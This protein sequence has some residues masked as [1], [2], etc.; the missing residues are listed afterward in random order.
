MNNLRGL[1]NGRQKSSMLG[2]KNQGYMIFSRMLIKIFLML[3]KSNGEETRK[4]VQM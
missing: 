1:P 4:D 3:T 2:K